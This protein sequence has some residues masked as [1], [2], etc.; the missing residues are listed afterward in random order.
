MKFLKNDGNL[1][2]GGRLEK[3]LG[4]EFGNKFADMPQSPGTTNRR[5]RPGAASA[6]GTQNWDNS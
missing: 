6:S 1:A 2:S 3:I 5:T 4:A